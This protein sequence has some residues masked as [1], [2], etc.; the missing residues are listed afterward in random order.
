M[1]AYKYLS[2][3][4][5]V[6]NGIYHLVLENKALFRRTLT[7]LLDKNGED[8]FVVSENYQPI[9]FNKTVFFVTNALSFSAAYKKIMTK[10]QSE[11]VEKANE[12]FFEELSDLRLA[13]NAFAEKLSFEF[14][15]DFTFDE[16]IDTSSMIKLLNFRVENDSGQHM[17]T[18]VQIFRILQKYMG[19]KLFVC[20][21]LSV[22]FT[23]EEL[24]E[25]SEAVQT[26]DLK[27]LN[28]ESRFFSGVEKEKVTYIDNDLCEIVD[29]GN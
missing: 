26:A 16:E 20:Y 10:I 12:L 4:I 25:L 14:D 28:I 23:L 17:E 21:N 19:I 2:K 11:L 7:A 15:F 1:I 27:I 18:M 24:R 22:F 9:V 5:E 13:M 3:P 29:N 6:D 8:W